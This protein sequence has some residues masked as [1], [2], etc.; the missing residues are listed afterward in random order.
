MIGLKLFTIAGIPIY[1]HGVGI[2]LAALLG[3]WLAQRQAKANGYNPEIILDFVVYALIGGILGARIWY[4]IFS[5]KTYVNNP[6][7]IFFIWE[8]GLA[9]Q[10]GLLGG[11]L[12]G[13][14]FAKKRNIPVWTLADIIAPGLILGMAIGRIGDFMAGDDYGIASEVFGVIYQPDSIAYKA[15]GPV[16]LFPTALFEATADL[17]IM[18]ILLMLKKR[19]LYEGFLFLWMLTLYSFARFFLE[20][21][22]GD[23]LRTFF[24]LRTAQ[25]TA[26]AT[27][28]ISV[29]FMIRRTKER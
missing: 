26:V 9:I 6:I 28:I 3:M 23:S 17:I 24:D 16:P 10:G 29:I 13:I 20:F 22:R 12:I 4:V 11:I 1:T 21:F 18:G 5:W 27:I 15:N 19:K 8:G 2:A 25:L 7:E 14:W